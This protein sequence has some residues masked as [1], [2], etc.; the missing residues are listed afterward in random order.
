MYRED[1]DDFAQM[2][3]PFVLERVVI[4]DRGAAVRHGG[5]EPVFSP[6][7]EDIRAS[8]HWWE[9]VRRMMTGFLQVP[10]EKR[11]KSAAATTFTKPVVTY[12]STQEKVLGPR[13]RA[14]DHKLF[15][16]ALNK[17]H[18]AHG[19]EVNIVPANIGWTDRMKVLV[20]ST[21]SYMFV[22]SSDPK[23]NITCRLLSASMALI[24]QTA[25]L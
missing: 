24:L 12:L 19:Y 16:K 21:V 9:P 18:K 4:A 2:H 1:W 8:R 20:R 14:E 23:L 10:E 7:F 3:I 15:V 17:L 25:I 11:S 5:S 6:P 13:L 22:F